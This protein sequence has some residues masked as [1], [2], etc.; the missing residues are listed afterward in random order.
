MTCLWDIQL[1]YCIPLWRDYWSMLFSKLKNFKTAL[2]N[3]YQEMVGVYNT[4][5]VLQL[6]HSFVSATNLA[7]WTEWIFLVKL[8]SFLFQFADHETF[9]NCCSSSNRPSW[10]H[11]FPLPCNA[12]PHHGI[13]L[14][15]ISCSPILIA[16]LHPYYSPLSLERKFISVDQVGS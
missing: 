11:A 6:L 15:R 9:T 14:L 13:M 10:R 4:W 8:M 12:P 7:F 16:S 2:G 3:I 5:L 1:C